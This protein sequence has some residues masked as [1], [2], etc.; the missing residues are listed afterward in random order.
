MFRYYDVDGAAREIEL[1]KDTLAFTVCQV[2]VVAHCSGPARIE[3]N[4][5]GSSMN[6]LFLDDATSTAIFERTGAVVRLDVFFALN[7]WRDT[8]R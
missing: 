6:G 4:G 3:I 5:N 2:P 1:V 8:Q 7:G